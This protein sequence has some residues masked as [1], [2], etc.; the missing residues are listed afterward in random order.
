MS[1][2][3]AIDY[4]R[5]NKIPYYIDE[6]KGMCRNHNYTAA[7]ESLNKAL[8]IDGNS[9]DVLA[10]KAWIN[11]LLFDLSIADRNG[12]EHQFFEESL[13]TYNKLLSINPEN[14]DALAGKGAILF[15]RG[16]LDE[17]LQ[18]LDKS[19]RIN[20][21]HY[22]A[23]RFKI[24]L[25][26]NL[27]QYDNALVN[28]QKILNE[29]S[30]EGHALFCRG[31]YFNRIGKYNDAVIN[32][33]KAADD[34][35]RLRL[36]SCI[37]DRDYEFGVALIGNGHYKD[38]INRLKNEIREFNNPNLLSAWYWKGIAHCRMKEYQDAMECFNK[39]MSLNPENIQ[40]RRV[41]ELSYINTDKIEFDQ[42]HVE[43]SRI[44]IEQGNIT[45]AKICLN[46]AF[47]LNPKNTDAKIISEKIN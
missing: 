33:K 34:F 47:E 15:K 43:K 10:E 1:L 22:V 18:C 24:Y 26:L 28:I 41:C 40:R 36:T 9:H 3:S 31:V 4:L 20:P 16:N 30:Y 12:K 13:Q 6:A 27:K 21:M 44:F 19:L 37:N 45:E 39:C 17:S 23:L 32:I 11:Q 5:G 2:W 42:I 8:E 7:L 38:G 14:S 35:H 46:K 25:D 29:D